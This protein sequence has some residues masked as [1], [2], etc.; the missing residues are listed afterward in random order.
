MKESCAGGGPEVASTVPVHTQ[1]RTKPLG[2]LNILVLVSLL[3]VKA[4]FTV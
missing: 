3:L 1:G 2:G 4:F